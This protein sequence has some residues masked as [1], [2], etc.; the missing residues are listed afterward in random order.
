MWWEREAVGQECCSM[1]Q[2]VPTQGGEGQARVQAGSFTSLSKLIFES[3]YLPVQQPPWLSSLTHYP[4]IFPAILTL[5]SFA[6][7]SSLSRKIISACSSPVQVN[8][9]CAIRW[10]FFRFNLCSSS[11]RYVNCTETTTLEECWWL[12]IFQPST[13]YRY[14]FE[15][16]ILNPCFRLSKL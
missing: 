10:H 7:S 14:C 12:I 2:E 11:R 13:W 8:I 5:K 15:N 16:T 6:V 4:L 1:A 3:C 9:L